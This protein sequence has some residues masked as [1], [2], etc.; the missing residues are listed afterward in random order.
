VQ[1]RTHLEAMACVRPLRRVRVA[2]RDPERARAFVHAQAPRYAFP[3]EAV[4]SVEEAVRSADLVVTATSSPSPVL[5][6]EWVAAGA[7]LN[8]IGASLRDR[9]EVDGATVAAASLFVDRRE[10]T[11]NES[12]DYLLAL[13]DGAIREGHIRAELGEVL[14]GRHPGRT[15]RD[16]ITLFKSLGLAVEDLAAAALVYERAKAKGAGQWVEF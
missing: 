9:R 10:S 11:E 16:E 14:A 4:A 6:R 12:G 8:V 7:H 3:L 5:R 2:S 13:Q 1:A 15:A